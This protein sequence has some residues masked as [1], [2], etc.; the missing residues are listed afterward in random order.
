[1]KSLHFLRRR[2]YGLDLCTAS[3]KQGIS[4]YNVIKFP[5]NVVIVVIRTRL[6]ICV[7]ILF[8]GFMESAPISVVGAPSSYCGSLLFTSGVRLS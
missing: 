1:M 8:L 3:D 4:D 6:P 7:H 5:L 2:C